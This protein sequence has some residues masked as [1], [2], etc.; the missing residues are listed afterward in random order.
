MARAA[1]GFTADPS[2][3]PW[4]NA[5]PTYT[6]RDNVTKILGNHTLQFGVIWRDCAE[7]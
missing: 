6:I 2:D 1:A 7:K 3:D 5:N 4:N